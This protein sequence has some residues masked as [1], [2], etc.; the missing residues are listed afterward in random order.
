[1]KRASTARLAALLLGVALLSTGCV[2]EIQQPLTQTN[3][4]TARSGDTVALSWASK[5]GEQY[6]IW[7]AE[8]LGGGS[9]WKVLPGCERLDGTGGTIEKTDRLPIGTQRYYRIVTKPA[10]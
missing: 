2:T 9:Q 6:A 5:R 7:Y 4:F 10:K 3:L 8:S 1:M